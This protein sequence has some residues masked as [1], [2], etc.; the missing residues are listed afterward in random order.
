MQRHAAAGS[1][2]ARPQYGGSGHG[3]GGGL[4]ID[5]DARGNRNPYHGKR[6]TDN[7]HAARDLDHPV[8]AA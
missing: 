1:R 2:R 5:T 3:S 8:K 6:P 4:T 7:T